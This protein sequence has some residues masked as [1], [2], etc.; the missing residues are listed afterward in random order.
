MSVTSGRDSRVD[1]GEER[2]RRLLS[3]ARCVSARVLRPAPA[4]IR[5]ID[6]RE[7]RRDHLPQLGEHQLG[8]RRATSASGCARIRSSSAS[9]A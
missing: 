4:A 3:K 6:A 7:K 5:L 2:A 8:V 1:A 9:Y